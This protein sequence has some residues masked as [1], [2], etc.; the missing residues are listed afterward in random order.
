MPVIPIENEVLE[1]TRTLQRMKANL[2][3]N[4]S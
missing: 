1:L 2:V 3:L 4:P